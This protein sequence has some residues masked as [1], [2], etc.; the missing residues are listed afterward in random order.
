M[1]RRDGFRQNGLMGSMGQILLADKM[2]HV[3]SKALVVL[4][5]TRWVMP[6]PRLQVASE[7]P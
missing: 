2:K 4:R 3:G 1:T 5:F 6:G 7:Q